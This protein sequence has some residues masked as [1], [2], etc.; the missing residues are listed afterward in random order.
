MKKLDEETALSILFANTKRKKRI[1]NLL[2]I[3]NACKYLVKLYGS[4][5]SVAKKIGISSEMIRQFLTPLKLPKKIQKLV[6][7]RKIDSIDIVKEITS[8]KEPF[9]QTVAAEAIINSLSKDV[10]DIKRLV[11]NSDVSIKGAKNIVLEAKPKGLNIFI[12]DF[13]NETFQAIKKQSKDLKTKPVELVRKIVKDWL[14]KK[15]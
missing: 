13:D 9:K 4:Q 11:K 15:R 8:I 7:E 3:A 14:K 1:D 5:K 10:R 2:V 12:M 6:S